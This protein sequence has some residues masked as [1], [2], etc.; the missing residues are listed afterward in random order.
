MDLI[1][2]LDLLKKKV[3]LKRAKLEAEITELENNELRQKVRAEYVTDKAK[4]VIKIQK[5]LSNESKVKEDATNHLVTSMDFIYQSDKL[6][7]EKVWETGDMKSITVC[8]A[9][10]L[11]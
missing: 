7:K 11:L 8:D 9:L 6:L 4:E 5:M 1:N 2:T 10:K 3:V